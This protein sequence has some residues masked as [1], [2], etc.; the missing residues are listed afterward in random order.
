MLCGWTSPA[1]RRRASTALLASDVVP[2]RVTLQ[3]FRR[4][5]MTM[6]VASLLA[7]L[8][9]L[10]GSAMA[11]AFA[12]YMR[13]VRRRQSGPLTGAL[14]R[15]WRLLF[16]FPTLVVWAVTFAAAGVSSTAAADTGHRGLIL[17]GYFVGFIGT[18]LVGWLRHRSRR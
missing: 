8:G 4:T 3:G 15:G 18:P 12:R 5:Q 10:V 16:V 1:E 13:W 11:F 9:I 7:V 14:V 17:L 6:I 2:S